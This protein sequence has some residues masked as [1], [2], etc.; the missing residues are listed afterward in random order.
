MTFLG[1]GVYGGVE[2]DQSKVSAITA[3]PEP[4]TIKDLKWFLGFANF[5]C[6]FICSYSTIASPLTSILKGKHLKW[7]DQ[8]NKAFLLLKQSFT[9]AL[10]LSSE[11]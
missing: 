5:Y 6:H 11:T 7:T 2:M 3:W 10:I 8:A 4:S 9:S 1:Y